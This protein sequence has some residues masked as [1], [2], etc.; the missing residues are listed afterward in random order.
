MI[1]IGETIVN[2]VSIYVG[3]II[4]KLYRSHNKTNLQIVSKQHYRKIMFINRSH[5]IVSS[6]RIRK[7]LQES[8]NTFPI[9]IHRMER[10]NLRI[11]DPL[12][13][14]VYQDF[15]IVSFIINL[16][17]N[18]RFDLI[19]IINTSFQGRKSVSW[20]PQVVKEVKA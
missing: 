10:E 18:R 4:A 8:W 14:I 20:L 11:E 7:Q 9:I 12:M 2:I 19:N 3:N 1:Y 5:Q 15:Q 16:S 13:Y 6:F 17:Q